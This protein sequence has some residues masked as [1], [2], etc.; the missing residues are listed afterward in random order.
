MI[1]I[2]ARGHDP[3]EPFE[4]VIDA[5]EKL[6]SGEEILLILECEP[7]SLYRFLAQNRCRYHATR[8]DDG[9]DEV[10]IWEETTSTPPDVA[11]R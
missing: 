6:E 5:L 10:R 7:A 3:P 4:R 8:F 2:D 1:T 11:A 9:R